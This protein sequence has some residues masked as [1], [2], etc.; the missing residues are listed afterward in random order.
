MVSDDRKMGGQQVVDDAGAA[1]FDYSAFFN[2]FIDAE[3]LQVSRDELAW[4]QTYKEPDRAA[5]V[6][7]NLSCG[8][9]VAPH[10]MLTQVALLTAL[11][12]DFVATAGRQFCC[13]RIYHRFGKDDLGDRLAASAITR[14]ASFQPTTN[15]Q[16]CG[17]CLIEFDYHV[18]KMR[19]AGN[20]PFEVVHIT[21]FLLDRLNE[22]GD[23]VPWKR[24]IPRRVLLHA[25]GAELHA[26]KEEARGAVIET[27]ALIPGVEYAGLVTDPSAGAPCS[28]VSP[29][30]PSILHDLDE[31]R[32]RQVQDELWAQAEAV[33]ADAI[34]T[35]HHLCHRE[36]CK[37]GS[38]RLPVIHYQ[39]LL[40]EALGISIPDRFQTLWKLGD[41]EKVLRQSRPHWS[42]WGIAEEQARE[43]VKD[44]F[45]PEY[46][47]AVQRCPCDGDCVDAAEGSGAACRPSW[48]AMVIPGADLTTAAGPPE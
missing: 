43:M 46:A 33:G 31:E 27:L 14:F 39:S 26:T 47:A 20:D 1:P 2:G 3:R 18:A 24:S 30:G 42:S 22:L 23:R 7:L 41:P 28:V 34:V 16:V 19:E 21:R 17:S 6:V 13:G 12:I 40:A 5:D 9:Q 4:M 29:G 25:E 35:H 8:E 37:F 32:Y 10:L 11:G 44:V 36:W 45:V 15:V 48:N 38:Q